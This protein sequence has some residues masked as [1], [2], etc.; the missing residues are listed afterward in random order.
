MPNTFT[1]DAAQGLTNAQVRARQQAGQINIQP[2][3][4]TKSTGRIIREHLCTFFNL[5]NFG[6]FIALLSVKSY[7]NLLFMGVVLSNL[8][9][10][11]IQEIRSKRTVEK[12]SLLHAPKVRVVREGARSEIGAEEI[13]LGDVLELSMGDQVPTDCLLLEGTVEVDESVLTGESK[14]IRKQAGDTLLSG[15]VLMSGLCRACVEKI[16]SSSYASKLIQEA[17]KPVRID[18]KL[19]RSLRA[20]IRFSGGAVLPLGIA[21]FVRAYL[22]MGSPLENA[23]EQAA[24]SMLGMIPAGLMLLTSVS[25]AVGVI[26][27]SRKGVL[28]QEPYCIEALARVDTLCLDKTGTLTTGRMTVSDVVCL[29]GHSREEAEARIRRLV[30]ATPAKNATAKALHELFGSETGEA[31]LGITAFSSARRYSAASFADECI[32]IGALDAVCPQAAEALRV[33]VDKAAAAGFRVLV[34]AVSPPGA[35]EP[36]TP[37]AGAQEPMALVLL[38]DEIRPEAADMLRFFEKE[39]VGVRVISGDDPRTV[40]HIAQRLNIQHAGQA[41]DLSG[42]QD[43]EVI[44]AATE[45][46]VFG[47]VS[48]Q[49][50]RLILRTLQQNGHTVCMTGDG[51]NDLLALREADCS[52]ALYNG[53]DA[54]RQAAHMVLLQN[55]FSTLP[56]VVMEGRRVINN[57]TRTASLFLVKTIFSFLLTLASVLFAVPYPFQPIQLT[58]ISACTVGIPSAV[59]SLE[60][61]RSRVKGSFIKNVLVNAIPGALCV[62]IYSIATYIIAPYFDFSVAERST[63]CVCLAGTAGLMVLLRVC[64]PFERRRGILWFSM[65]ALFFTCATVLSGWFDLSWIRGGKMLVLYLCMAACSYPMLLLLSRIVRKLLRVEKLPFRVKILEEDP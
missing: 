55:D 37:E 32:Y 64:L 28:V 35:E 47:R 65:V 46:T 10:G 27:L 36:A 30:G 44:A 34:L 61:N 13:V 38:Q 60:P 24:G 56:Q 23:V 22:Q 57:I 7:N 63:L 8:L 21:L 9:I 1:P 11:V 52:V 45:Y 15:S 54:A 33:Q 62:F 41:I 42:L 14:Y 19:M 53:S 6:L 17:R 43:E 40:S 48:P 26:T 20:I 12:L 39:G 25:L 58:L 18:S 16:G 29:N 3:P 59:L 50:K 51:V 31:A 5:L 2:P 49:Q 4:I